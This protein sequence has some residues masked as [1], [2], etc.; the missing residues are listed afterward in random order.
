MSG[1][2]ILAADF[3]TS[4]VKVALVGQAMG[5]L[6][7]AFVPY[8]LSLGAS[9][10]AEQAPADWWSALRAAVDIMRRDTGDLTGR[11]A[12]ITFCAQFCG[13]VCVDENAEP[14]RPAMIWLDK[15]AA[16]QA[17]RLVGGLPTILGYNIPRALLWLVLANGAPSRNGMDPPCK[18]IWLREREPETWRRTRYLLDVKDWLVAKATG[19]VVT[20]GDSANLTWMMDTRP[21]R[22][23]WSPILQRVVGVSGEMLPR[24]VD[25]ASVAGGLA[26][27][28]AADLG[29]DRD[30]PVL[31]GTND[32]TA[33]ALGCGAVGDS[34]LHLCIG[35]SSWIGC[36]HPRRVVSPSAS[37]A[38]IDSGL[39]RRPLLIATQESGGSA[40]DWISGIT[41]ATHAP[42]GPTEPGDPFFVPWLAGERAPLDDERMRASF[43]HLSL[44][45]D[46]NAL[47]R[48]VIEGVAFNSRWIHDKVVAKLGLTSRSEP[49][50]L[51]GGG[52]L[53]PSLV[54]KLADALQR[55]M[56]LGPN[57][58]A[59]VL[60]AATIGA[61]H[62][63]WYPDV[64]AAA[65][66][67][68]ERTQTIVEPEPAASRLAGERYRNLAKLRPHLIRHYRR[69]NPARVP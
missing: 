44:A 42:S 2:L 6:H 50:A 41:G 35:H 22:G 7:H 68:A 8:P 37:F 11:I 61:A 9:D 17:R 45:H 25:G 52:A 20:T 64:W 66:A 33:A 43:T 15:R 16:P 24:I 34:E 32:V 58:L 26:A 51:V 62:A 4:G 27:S 30:I 3:G 36:F 23:N 59:G 47:R 21:G 57:R 28:A 46:G 14:L 48:A 13:V 40:I 19:S 65:R 39:S 10:V 31:A 60:G 69:F 53:N 54:Q 49:L 5:L 29:L 63:G 1:D 67:L 38:T 56:K 55:P 12:A 18:M